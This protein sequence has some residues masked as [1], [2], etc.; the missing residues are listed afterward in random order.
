MYNT[1]SH[2]ASPCRDCNH[3][4]LMTLTQP[5]RLMRIQQTPCCSHW[6]HMAHLS[7]CDQSSYPFPS[8]QQK[9]AP[10]IC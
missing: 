1:A 9:G 5:S 6:W 7:Y 4:G 8:I 3:S 2:W 10:T